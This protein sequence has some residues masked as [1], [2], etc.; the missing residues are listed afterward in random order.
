MSLYSAAPQRSG[1]GRLWQRFARR[2]GPDPFVTL[3]LQVRLGA[4]ADHLRRIEGDPRM[5]ARGERWLAAREAYDAL[6]A[7]A[8]TVAGVERAEAPNDDERLRVELELTA[9]GWSW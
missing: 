9:R 8:C 5:L 7:D 1:L 6:L 4:V 2:P 3:A